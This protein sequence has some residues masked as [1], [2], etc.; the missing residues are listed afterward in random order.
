MKYWRLFCALL[1]AFLTVGSVLALSSQ[2][3]S[4]DSETSK[5]EVFAFYTG[6][7]DYWKLYD[8]NK[9]TSL[10]IFN[11]RDLSDL[12]LKDKARSNDVRVLSK[13][14]INTTCIQDSICRTSWIKDQIELQE[15]YGLEGV[16]IDIE[17]GAAKG[18]PENGNLTLFM[19]ELRTAL[20]PSAQLTFDAAWSPDCIDGRCYNFTS[21]LEFVDFFFVMSYD[22]Q[23][24]M[25]SPPCIADANTPMSKTIKGLQLYLNIGIPP[26]RLV[27][28]LP[29]YGYDYVCVSVDNGS[30]IIHEV[31][32]RG[33]PCSD[34]AGT[35]VTLK[36]L[37]TKH[38]SLL[39]KSVL[40]TGTYSMVYWYEDEDNRK[41]QVW[42]DNP[43]TL[44]P[45][46]QI[47]L[48]MKLRGVGFWSISYL[49]Y[50]SNEEYT[51][52]TNDMWNVIPGNAE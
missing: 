7:D 44:T 8:W 34:A 36:N 4:T 18:S 45:K 11:N 46:Y 41:H 24:Q 48:Q 32:F 13:G 14:S 50:G 52:F 25:G 51:R 23:S 28:G 17:W 38:E 22:E 47:A 42:Y 19:S 27:L 20:K 29:W 37:L 3:G 30:C 6:S 31:P 12:Q 16:N 10:I 40:S 33:S 49:Y 15:E 39:S 2:S 9:L 5:W 21:F 26:S 1:Q 35:E 43:L